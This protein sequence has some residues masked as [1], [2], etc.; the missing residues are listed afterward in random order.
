MVMQPSLFFILRAILEGTTSATVNCCFA[1]LVRAYP[2][3]E[4]KVPLDS[5]ECTYGCDT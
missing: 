3:Q 2:L 5:R 4:R 1:T